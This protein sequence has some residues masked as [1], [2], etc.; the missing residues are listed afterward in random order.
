L[1]DGD[2]GGFGIV[3]ECGEGGVEFQEAKGEVAFG[4][5]AEDA[6]FAE[7]RAAGGEGDEAVAGDAEAGIDAEDEHGGSLRWEWWRCH[8]MGLCNSR[9]SVALG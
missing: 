3:E 9:K 1:F 4:F 5:H 7:F 8:G 2:M 6:G